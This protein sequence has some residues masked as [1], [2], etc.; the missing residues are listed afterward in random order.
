MSVG[1]RL[2]TYTNRMVSWHYNNM[3]ESCKLQGEH[4]LLSPLLSPTDPLLP[5]QLL[6]PTFFHLSLSP[7][8]PL[9]LSLSRIN[10]MSAVQMVESFSV[11]CAATFLLAGGASSDLSPDVQLIHK[12]GGAGVGDCDSGDSRDYMSMC[13]C[14][15]LRVYMCLGG[16]RGGSQFAG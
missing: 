14:V 10:Q 8:L 3:P 5:V 2:G 6:S 7:S 1:T 15:C 16:R 11:M 12:H 13:V 9:S 4:Q